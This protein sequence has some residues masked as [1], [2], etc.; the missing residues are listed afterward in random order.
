MQAILI[1]NSGSSSIK[2]AVFALERETVRKE[3]T[4]IVVNIIQKP[5]LKIKASSGEVIINKNL[6]ETTP[7]NDPYTRAT[8]EILHW[9]QLQ[10]INVIAAGHR[11]AHGGVHYNRAT[12]IN[13][14]VII[15]LEELK[16]LAPLHQ[17]YNLNGI[18]I[19]QKKF[20][21]IFQVACL[22]TAFHT[23][24]NPLSQ[25]FAIPKWL[26][27]KGV[28][29]YGFHGLSYDYVV[30]QFDK[31][32][33]K[34]KVN[35]KFII[36][37][38]GQGATMCAVHNR[39]SVATSIGFSALDGLPMGTRCGCLDAGVMLYLLDQEKMTYTEIEKTLYKESGLLGVSGGIGSDMKE[40]LESNNKDAK[41]AVDLFIY[42][43]C[44]WIGTL[45]AELQGLDGL[46]FTAGIGENA[47][48]IREKVC[49]Q[50]AWLGAKIDKDANN[51]GQHEIYHQ[52]SKLLLYTI[53]TD[54]E[55]TIAKETFALMTSC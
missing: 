45:T 17:P 43:I 50:I 21:K 16:P 54:E 35:G 46:I 44:C 23:T 15:N 41:T 32:L 30:S 4:G 19:L 48:Y 10:Q 55:V 36:A 38:L 47:P 8:E 53:P 18:K 7:S 34:D 33:P 1:L 20:P 13:D 37:H 26:T 6:S 42:R 51:S 52:D 5:H 39:K 9:V 22:D 49:E 29:R 12:V 28:R 24:C 40:L 11:V 27:E 2:F 25:L 14:E 3:Y 31:Y